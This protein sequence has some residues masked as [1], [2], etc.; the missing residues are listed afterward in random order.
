MVKRIIDTNFWDDA[1]VVEKY[2]PEDKYFMLYLMTNPKTTS[3]GIYPFVKKQVAFDLGY[4]VDTVSFLLERFEKSYGKVVYD[5]EHKEIAVKNSLKFTIS[6]GGK[7]VEDMIDRELKS[8]KSGKLIQETY[9]DMAE[10]WT[11]SNREIDTTIKNRFEE[12]L[13]KRNIIIN[14]NTNA[15]AN[16]NTDTHN[17]S[18]HDSSDKSPQSQKR[19]DDNSPYMKLAQRLLGHIQQRDPKYKDRNMQTW[20]DDMRKLVELD[21]RSVEEVERVL[22]WSQQDTFWQTNILSP[23]K[24]RKHFSKLYQQCKAKQPINY[25]FTN[26]KKEK[27]P[28]PE[29]IAEFEKWKENFKW[30]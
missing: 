25:T 17:D 7:P 26:D 21:N 28:T 20:A 15:N 29:E 18:L 5:D 13:K 6:K 3:I 1:L 12:E 23:N 10:W 22:D 8:V 9:K 19:Y 16:A 24:L 4:S 2:T 27:E 11:I 14:T 30:E